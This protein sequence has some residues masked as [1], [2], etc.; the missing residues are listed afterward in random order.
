[1]TGQA[2]RLSETVIFSNNPRCG[3][4]TLG[5]AQ[6]KHGLVSANRKHDLLATPNAHSKIGW[7]R[8]HSKPAEQAG[9]DQ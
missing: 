1:M 3:K 2:S 7:W 8:A 5:A 4:V 9:R 6:A